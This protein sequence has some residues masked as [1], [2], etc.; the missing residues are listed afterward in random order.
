MAFFFDLG[1]PTPLPHF[2]DI[3]CHYIPLHFFYIFISSTMEKNIH[4]PDK[5]RY[6]IDTKPGD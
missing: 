2:N 1:Y 3:E 5:F 4:G 6:L